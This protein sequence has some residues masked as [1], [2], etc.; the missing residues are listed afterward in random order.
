MKK[1]TTFVAIATLTAT[2]SLIG[3]GNTNAKETQLPRDDAVLY[4]N[5]SVE[6]E[7]PVIIRQA[8]T[9]VEEVE[10]TDETNETEFEEASAKEI[11][12]IKVIST[13]P[14][15]P[16]IP[17]E[18]ELIQ[19]NLIYCGQTLGIHAY[20]EAS[21]QSI[22]STDLPY[23]GEEV[24]DVELVIFGVTVNAIYSVSDSFE[25]IEKIEYSTKDNTYLSNI[26]ITGD[27]VNIFMIQTV[28]GSHYYIGIKY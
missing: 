18:D 2:I 24:R 17:L 20:D 15:L 28:N 16:Q 9:V 14:M 8:S 21:M 3:C 22:H 12:N 5:V 26:Y 10:K 27:D 13:S 4:G 19:V 23:Y 25:Q 6:Y 1:K 11:S 7:P